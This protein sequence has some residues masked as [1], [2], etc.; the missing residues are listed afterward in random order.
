MSLKNIVWLASYPKSGNTWTRIFLANYLLNSDKPVPINQVHRIGIGDSIA[1]TYALVNNG[2]YDPAD[3]ITHLKGRD[4]VMRRIVSNHADM[5]F[6]KTH[7]QNGVAFGHQLILPRYTMKAIYI[8]RDP[9]DMVISYAR[10]YG[11]TPSETIDTISRDDNATLADGRNVEQYLGTW[12]NHVLGWTNSRKF[13]VHTMRYED[14]H[15]EPQR[16]FGD[17]LTFLSIPIDAARLDKA[18]RF[19]S[20]DEVR[21]QEDSDSFIEKSEKAEKFFHTGTTGQWQ[22]VL[23]DKDLAKLQANAG[24]VMAKFGYV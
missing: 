13:P 23:T 2:V 3:R 11:Q 10:H 24:K 22:R 21:A 7:N 1:K 18:I 15:A 17:L 6:V 12:S 5:N 8:L 14:M 16:T 20:F 19:S 9:R 4:L